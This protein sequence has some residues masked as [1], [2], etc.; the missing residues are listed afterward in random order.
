MKERTLSFMLS[1][2][3]YKNKAGFSCFIFVL[4]SSVKYAAHSG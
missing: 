4:P 3:K 1:A 2:N